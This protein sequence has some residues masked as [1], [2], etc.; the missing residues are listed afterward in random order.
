MIKIAPSLLAADFARLGDDVRRAEQA[1]ADMMHIDVMDGN[2]VKPITIGAQ[3]V[4]ALRPHCAAFFDVHLM[5]AH[6]E[7]QIADMIK[8][9]ADG[10][11]I[12]LESGG[13]TAGMLRTI[14]EL[15]AQSALS[16]NPDTPIERVYPYLEQVG[17]VLI[18]SVYP[19]FGGQAYLPGST[20]RI[21]QLH[22]EIVR[23]GL[24]VDIQVDGGINGQTAALAR[25][26]GANVLVAGSYVFGAEDMAAAIRTLRAEA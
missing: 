18:M 19:G 26:A 7:Y 4:A 5:V 14:R 22:G 24:L 25:K 21:A 3:M 20:Q 2:F 23:R 6:P 8:S 16:I 10:V 13:D 17:M 9:G 15:G 11:T 1:G 12:H